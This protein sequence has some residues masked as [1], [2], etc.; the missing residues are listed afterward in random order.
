[1]QEQFGT[2]ARTAA[3]DCVYAFQR[4]P[5]TAGPSVTA[6]IRAG[7]PTFCPLFDL[8]GVIA[9]VHK[10]SRERLFSRWHRGVIARV[11][12]E[13]A[14][15]RTDDGLSA[16]SGASALLDLPFYVGNKVLRIA[17]KLAQRLGLP[18]VRRISLD[19]PRTLETARALGVAG[20]ALQRLC[21]ARVLAGDRDTVQFSRALFDRLLTSGMTIM[22]ISTR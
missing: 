10:P 15:L 21:D 12:P 11:A 9:S 19:D 16:R 22:E 4:I 18:D 8:D 7:L 2:L 3:N 6:G 1:M 5:Y 14:N 20:P 17:Q 13:I